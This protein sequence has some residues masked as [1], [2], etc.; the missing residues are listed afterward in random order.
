MIGPYTISLVGGGASGKTLCALKLA[1]WFEAPRC[2]PHHAHSGPGQGRPARGSGPSEACH[3][4]APSEGGR[5]L[6]V[7]VVSADMSPAA[8]AHLRWLGKQMV[9]RV[10]TTGSCVLMAKAS[11]AGAASFL[12]AARQ[13]ASRLNLDVLI[14]DSGNVGVDALSD[15]GLA[16]CLTDSDLVLLLVDACL[17]SPFFLSLSLS[18][19]L[20]LSFVA[21]TCTLGS[22]DKSPRVN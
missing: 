10:L 14:V 5:A 16:G 2:A 17:G 3:G 22:I 18:L 12:A 11:C 21:L 9:I 8:Q 19:C 7:G 4:S 15:A 1:H 20:I 6:L 13:E